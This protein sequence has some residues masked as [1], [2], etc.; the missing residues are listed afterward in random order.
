MAELNGCIRDLE[1]YKREK[2]NKNLLT[3]HL[4]KMLA[5]FIEWREQECELMNSMDYGKWT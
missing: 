3:G 2:R 5:M 4:E 1:P